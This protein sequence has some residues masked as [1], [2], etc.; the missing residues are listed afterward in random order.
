MKAKGPN[1]RKNVTAELRHE[2]VI[3]LRSIRKLGVTVPFG[4][5]DG[6][7]QAID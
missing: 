1:N 4:L 3:T 6:P 2:L 7:S 5:L